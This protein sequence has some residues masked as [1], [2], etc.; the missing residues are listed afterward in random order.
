MGYG[1]TRTKYQLREGESDQSIFGLPDDE[2]RARL[3][4][5]APD[6]VVRFLEPFTDAEC[7][8]IALM[9]RER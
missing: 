2:A 9:G 8:A 6:D 3:L 5:G 7:A 4:D 1:I